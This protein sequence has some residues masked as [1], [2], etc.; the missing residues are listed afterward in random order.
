MRKIISG[1]TSKTPEHL[2]LDSGAF[3]KNYDVTKDT[4]ESAVTAGKLIGATRNGGKFDAIPEIRQ[5]EV[6]GVKGPAKGLEMLDAWNVTIG[7]NVLEITTD[8]LAMAL[9]STE[10]DSTTNEKYDI[11]KA[12]N[13]IEL[14]DYI[15][16]ITWV[17]T[18]SG[19]EEPVI[20]QVLNAL[21]MGGLSL[22]T[23]MKNEAVTALNF[24][25]H[26]TA[27]DLNTPPFVIYYPKL[28]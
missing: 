3:F 2:L 27:D 9:A 4:F 7:A 6:D 24:T 22:Q 8:T 25:G 5:I 26:Y 20:I 17:G 18:L 13:V 11:I 28:T 12:N 15:D 14:D 23:Q 1:F 10:V 19:S 16:N 21:N